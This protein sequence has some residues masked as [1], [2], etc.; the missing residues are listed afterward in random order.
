MVTRRS[1]CALGER[2]LKPIEYEQGAFLAQELDCAKYMEC[3]VMAQQGL[4]DVFDEAIRAALAVNHINRKGKD[5][6]KK[7]KCYFYE[8]RGTYLVS[9]L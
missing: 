2:G 5:M 4:Q 1:T 8:T 6:D 3:S 7:A 9:P